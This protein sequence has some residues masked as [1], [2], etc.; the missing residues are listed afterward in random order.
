MGRVDILRIFAGGMKALGF[1]DSDKEKRKK[2]LRAFRIWQHRPYELKPLSE[3][4][5]TC[6]SCKTEYVGNFCPRCGQS[7]GVG[8]FSLKKALL[9]FIDVWGMGN[10]SMFRSLRDLLLR[11]G[12]M[13]RDY[14][15]GMQSAYFP[16]FKMFFLLTALS[17]LVQNGFSLGL[18][19][20]DGQKQM[21][22]EVAQEMALNPPTP[23]VAPFKVDSVGVT[24]GQ[25]AT[26]STGVTEDRYGY[27][28]DNGVQ[29]SVGTK[30]EHSWE[31]SIL[32]S[33]MSFADVMN[34]IRKKNAA[35][36]ALLTLLIFTVPLYYFWRKTPTIPDLRYAEF[37]V[38]LVYTANM[39]TVYS[40]VANLLN[41][42]LLKTL[43]V[44]MVFVALKQF[45]GYS[46]KRVLGHLILTILI[47]TIILCLIAGSGIGVSYLTSK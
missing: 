5:H 24:A 28:W 47:S 9:L 12:Y 36:F 31:R 33:A 25:E 1:L 4:R 30:D 2:W 17:L 23:P 40:I 41:S 35:I 11:P 18:E 37:V 26:D 39:Y 6:A 8:R 21:S 16:P 3:E 29:V 38:A 14:L 44:L 34:S 10:R 27:R 43:A 19:E 15:R 45:S 32:Q 7:A 46:K 42:T 22:E 20:E 13:I